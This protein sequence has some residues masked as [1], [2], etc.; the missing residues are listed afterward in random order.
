M[1][2][3]TPA[4]KYKHGTDMCCTMGAFAGLTLLHIS[5]TQRTNIQKPQTRLDDSCRTCQKMVTEDYCQQYQ[6]GQQLLD[7]FC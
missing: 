7:P 6:V 3:C 4:P 5:D 1:G 2:D